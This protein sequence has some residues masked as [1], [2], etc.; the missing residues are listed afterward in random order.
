[1]IAGGVDGFDL[2]SITYSVTFNVLNNYLT[3]F[4][5]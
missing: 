4:R 2:N 3:F 1:V 5:G